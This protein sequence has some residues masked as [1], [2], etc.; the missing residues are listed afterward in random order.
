MHAICQTDIV[1]FT[2]WP[3]PLGVKLNYWRSR[4]KSSL[5]Q[6][7]WLSR[8][9]PELELIA[10]TCPLLLQAFDIS[11]FAAGFIDPNWWGPH[12]GISGPAGFS[13]IIPQVIRLHSSCS[14]FCMRPTRAQTSCNENVCLE[15]SMSGQSNVLLILVLVPSRTCIDSSLSFVVLLMAD[16]P[17]WSLGWLYI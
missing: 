1:I 2:Y 17:D 13:S 10:V 14:C 8:D 4:S 9:R 15:S 7:Q 6:K 12:R 5:F 3:R 16:R 11:S